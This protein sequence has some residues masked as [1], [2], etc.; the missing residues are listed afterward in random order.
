MV[1]ADTGR[2]FWS[3]YWT[4]P[5][6]AGTALLMGLAA[7][8]ALRPGWEVGALLGLLSALKLASEIAVLKHGD[9]DAD[10]WTPLRRTAVL[11]R[12]P[13]RPLLVVRALLGI[14]GGLVIPYLVG[15]GAMPVEFALWAWFLAG[16]CPIYAIFWI[17]WAIAIRPASISTFS[18][19]RSKN[20][21]KPLFCLMLPKTD[22]TSQGLFFRCAIPFSVF[23]RSAASSLCHLALLLTSMILIPI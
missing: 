15:V 14:A 2:T 8:W 1:Y 13:L 7:A 19:P 4:A 21:L 16:L 9:S 10:Q 3:V 12:G 22:S 6:F 17:L 18:I 23:K 5:R 20:L 11:Q